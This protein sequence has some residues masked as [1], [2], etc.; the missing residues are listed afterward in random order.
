MPFKDKLKGVFHH[1]KT[2]STSTPTNAQPAQAVPPPKM[3]E[4][5]GFRK[6]FNMSREDESHPTEGASGTATPT[7]NTSG[8]NDNLKVPSHNR[9]ADQNNGS[10]MYTVDP[11]D[12]DYLSVS[13]RTRSTIPDDSSNGDHDPLTAVPSLD[14]RDGPPPPTGA[15]TLSPVAED[16][17]ATPRHYDHTNEGA[18][19]GAAQKLE[20]LT[21]EQRDP[22]YTRAQYAK[23]EA[24]IE[25]SKF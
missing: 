10:G 6:S 11:Y 7:S 9:H 2:P 12:G 19:E 15:D 20:R 14:L 22:D 21:T 1:K 5:P 18:V 24:R 23:D 16:G 3:R 25:Q 4:V 13:P 8:A 17:K